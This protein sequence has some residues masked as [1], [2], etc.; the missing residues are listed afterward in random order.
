MLPPTHLEAW[1]MRPGAVDAM[2]GDGWTALAGFPCVPD[3]SFCAKGPFCRSPNFQAMFKLLAKKV[4]PDRVSGDMQMVG[5]HIDGGV[6]SRF[7]RADEEMVLVLRSLQGSTKTFVARPGQQWQLLGPVEDARKARVTCLGN[8]RRSATAHRMMALGHRGGLVS[9]WQFEGASPWKEV[10][11]MKVS[12]HD[13]ESVTLAVLSEDGSL[14]LAA[15]QDNVMLFSL[16][17]DNEAVELKH[18]HGGASQISAASIASLPG[19]GKLVVLAYQRG[20]LEGARLDPVDPVDPPLVHVAWNIPR[21][22]V[23]VISCLEPWHQGVDQELPA[24]MLAAGDASGS[25]TVWSL[26]AAGD[27]ASPK[28]SGRWSGMA[29]KRWP[30]GQPVA[31]LR[32]LHIKPALVGILRY[33]QQ[34]AQWLLAVASGKDVIV[35][36][37]L[38]GQEIHHGVAKQP[39]LVQAMEWR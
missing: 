14:L 2:G 12:H 26:T 23:M 32:L 21:D 15:S 13:W 31:G 35:L 16:P 19:A 11:Q 4:L 28:G 27:L 1:E 9:L 6:L 3:L 20:G 38:T 36:D 7:R 29:S 39:H 30:K 34:K 5:E 10:G 17:D 8:I 33:G 22:G 25:V 24:L 18:L 37:G